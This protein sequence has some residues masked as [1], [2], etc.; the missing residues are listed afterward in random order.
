MTRR[1]ASGA[2]RRK[3]DRSSAQRDFR[4]Q[5]QRAMQA[6]RHAQY[7]RAAVQLKRPPTRHRS[8]PR[9]PRK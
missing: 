6:L 7:D 1:T 4:E 2:D 3:Q 5:A 8:H 9:R